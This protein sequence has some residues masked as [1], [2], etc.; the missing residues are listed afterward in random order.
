MLF[1]GAPRWFMA[2]IKV[3]VVYGD[4]RQQKLLA[5]EVEKDATIEEVIHRSG[6][7]DVFPE[8][9]LDKNKVGVFSKQK[10]L[11]DLVQDG[12]RIEIYRSLQID[13][14]EARRTRAKRQKK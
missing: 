10:K 2:V 7:L 12:D 6:I 5:V 13:P 9:D 4:S 8:I 11:L 1:A 14:K 3:E